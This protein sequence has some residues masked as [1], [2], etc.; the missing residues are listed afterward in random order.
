MIKAAVCDDEK[1]FTKKLALM[2]KEFFDTQNIEINVS[3][4]DNGTDFLLSK[5]KY[6]IVFLDINIPDVGGFEIAEQITDRDRKTLIIFVTEHDELV[7]SSLKFRPFR[8]IRKCRLQEELPDVL[9]DVINE[10]SKKSSKQKLIYLYNEHDIP[11]EIKDI[12]YI[13]VIGHRIHTH[14]K[15]NNVIN[16]YGSLSKT[17]ARHMEYGFI[18]VHKS[19]IINA[20]QIAFSKNNCV[21]LKSGA[22]VPISR[23]KI[24]EFKIQYEK[25]RSADL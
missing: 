6:D 2:I 5:A 21:Y 8:F 13:E 9:H 23:N 7:Y 16:F 14:L 17:A 12:E 1:I 15:D 11:I 19:Y 22:V 20:E 24:R 18:R 25:I 4:F 3:V 10:I